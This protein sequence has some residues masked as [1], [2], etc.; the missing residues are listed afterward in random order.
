[1][2]ESLDEDQILFG[3]DMNL[4]WFVQQ[5]TDKEIIPNPEVGYCYVHKMFNPADLYIFQGEHYPDAEVLVHPEC[6]AEVQGF[7]DHILST[8]G[9]IRI[10]ASKKKTFLIGTEVDMVTRLRRENPDKI[11]HPLDEAIC[12]NMKLHTLEKVKNSLINKE[13]VVK[14]PSDI[15]D[16]AKHSIDRMLNVS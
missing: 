5:Q 1:M 15:A 14:V 2:V 3:P 6:D 7:A 12:E 8:G 9:M 11:I 13:F 10:S 4:A 16:K